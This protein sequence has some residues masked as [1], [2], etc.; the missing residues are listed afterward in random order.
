M[1]AGGATADE[2]ADDAE[3]TKLDVFWTFPTIEV[4]GSIV[5]V[6]R[7]PARLK[8]VGWSADGAREPWRGLRGGHNA[9]VFQCA[10]VKGVSGI[11]EGAWATRVV[12]GSLRLRRR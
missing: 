6:A 3:E 12:G 7:E 9:A 10:L 4:R 2:G 8:R 11:R 1:S 5:W